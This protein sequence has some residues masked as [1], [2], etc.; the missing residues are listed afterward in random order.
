MCNHRLDQLQAGDTRKARMS[1]C[2]SDNVS[3]HLFI[4]LTLVLTRDVASIDNLAAGST[5]VSHILHWF[6]ASTGL[7]SAFE[8][9]QSVRAKCAAHV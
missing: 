1:S 6:L 5:V 2:L 3:I 7:S 4:Y 9:A 8:S